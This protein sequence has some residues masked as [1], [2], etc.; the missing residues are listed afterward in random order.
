M[1]DND[2]SFKSYDGDYFYSDVQLIRTT[3]TGKKCYRAT[4]WKCKGYRSFCDSKH[5]L[6]WTKPDESPEDA[7]YREVSQWVDYPGWRDRGY[8]TGWDRD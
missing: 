1:S 8:G 2:L 7:H 6:I 3:S 5:T 4:Y